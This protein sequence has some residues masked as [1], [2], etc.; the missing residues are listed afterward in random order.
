MIIILGEKFI[1]FILFRFHYQSLIAEKK[2]FRKFFIFFLTDIRPRLDANTAN[3]NLCLPSW[4]NLLK[5][6][7]L[8]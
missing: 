6:L 3:E 5:S 8:K 1:F 4:Q 7:K 2:I